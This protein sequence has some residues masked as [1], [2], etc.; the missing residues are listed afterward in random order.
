MWQRRALRVGGLMGVVNTATHS[1]I[2]GC[3]ITESGQS[4]L[5]R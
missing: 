2:E 5:E 4:A 1:T 3:R